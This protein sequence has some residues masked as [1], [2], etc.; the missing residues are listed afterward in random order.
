M[1]D[2]ALGFGEF[3][4]GLAWLA[5]TLGLVTAIT[6]VLL[7]RRCA[8]LPPRAAVC[9]GWIIG[10]AVLVVVHVVPAAVGVLS[11]PAVLIA[12]G[13]CLGAALLVSPAPRMPRA[14]PEPPTRDTTASWVIAGLAVGAFLVWLAAAA[15]GRVLN[16]V[17]GT[18]VATQNLPL[19]ANWID[20]GSFWNVNEFSPLVTH[21]S[22][23]HNSVVAFLALVLPWDSDFAVRLLGYALLPLTAFTA[24]ALAR[25]LGAP[26]ATAATLG[27][28]GTAVPVLGFATVQLTMPDVVLFPSFL[29][30]VFFLVRHHRTGATA[31]LVLAGV[32]LGL[33]FGAKW[34]GVSDVAVVLVVW[35]IASL[36]AGRAVA[37]V[38][39][40]AAALVGLIVAFGGIWLVRNWVEYGNP[41]YPLDVSPLGIELWAAP[42]DPVRERAGESLVG[43]L[44]DPGMFASHLLPV[45]RDS[46]GFVGLALAIGAAVVAGWVLLRRRARA[47][48][49][50]DGATAAVAV[51]ALAVLAAYVVTP[52]TAGPEGSTTLASINARYALPGLLLAAAACAAA[53][54]WS[55]RAR[56]VIE[57]V[58]LVVLLDALSRSASVTLGRVA[59]AAIVV[60]GVAGIVYVARDRAVRA[61][62]GHRAP[63][64]AGALALLAIVALVGGY[65]GQQRYAENRLAQDPTFAAVIQRAPPGS[66]I[67]TAGLWEPDGPPPTLAMLGPKMQNEVSYLG[68]VVDSQ[69]RR[70]SSAEELERAVR[71][72]GFDLI[73]AGNAPAPESKWLR[74]MD[75]PVLASSARFTLYAAGEAS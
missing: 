37:A 3:A 62:H 28:A 57:S 42:P 23:P 39:R 12:A 18:D 56:W 71:E 9:A 8:G 25:E 65:R 61:F 70:Y 15:S 45:L 44:G 6:A 17:D 7:R 55:A 10:F 63:A 29:G 43:A 27:V 19:I 46:L 26:R 64:L 21:G 36:V 34:Y 66:T 49:W 58:A 31:D 13:I 47:A 48:S 24:F 32:G 5:L 72:G 60:A 38:A 54:G 35:A 53:A 1:N 75:L 52:Y 22:Y 50:R 4:I 74:D 11:R 73:I 14:E 67:A 33:A 41:L 2:T 59:I 68:P 30:A 51:A 40:Q 16:P 69:L 20:T